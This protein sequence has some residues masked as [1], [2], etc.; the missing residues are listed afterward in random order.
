MEQ[1]IKKNIR[2][3]SERYNHSIEY[4]INELFITN[5]INTIKI[6]PKNKYGFDIVYN[7]DEGIDKIC[8]NLEDIYDF[9]IELLRRTELYKLIPKNGKLLDLSDWIKEEDGDWIIKSLKV[10]VT[11]FD[12]IQIEY[13]EFGGNRYELEF[14]KGLLIL[15][16]D[17]CICKSNVIEIN[18]VC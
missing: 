4:G 12:D 11:K 9:L 15:N 3:L 17:L 6:H 13:K 7:T 1:L 8:S 18:N 16:D 10:L 2:L 14:Y 5:K